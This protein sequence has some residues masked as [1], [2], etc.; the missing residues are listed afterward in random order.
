LETSYN[1]RVYRT[2]VYRGAKVTSY[3]VRWKVG[4]EPHSET[5]RNSTQADS[6]RSEIVA[7]AR[8]GEAF[9]VETG[10]PVSLERKQETPSPRQLAWYQ[11]ACSYA[12]MKWRYSSPNYRRSIAEALTDATEALL[13]DAPMR[14]PSA[15][16]RKALR[17]WAFS[18]RIRNQESAPPPELASVI[19]WLESNTVAMAELNGADGA[20]LVRGVLDRLSTLLNG[21][22][23]APNTAT[24]KR[25]VFVNAMSYACETGAL[26]ADPL[27]AV[28]WT[29]PRLVHVVDP[30]TV[31]NADQARSF[32]AAVRKQGEW[33]TRLEAFFASM[34][35]AALRPEEV[36]ELGMPNLRSLPETGWGELLLTGAAPR[37]GTLW[38]ENGKSRER[39]PLKHRAIADSRTVPAHPE[40]VTVLL[41][42]I[43][44]FGPVT[45]RLFTGPLGGTINERTYLAVFHAARSAVLSEDEL[46]SPLLDVPYALRHA[47]VSTWL[48]AG[49]PATQ[50][51]EW[52]GHSVAVLLRVY[53]KCIAGK[54]DEAKRLIDAATRP[55]RS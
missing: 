30:R 2:E 29:K 41:R 6:F 50:V 23:A 3:R 27:A 43:E 40:L 5:F 7:A 35:Y 37:S 38:T 31:V 1:V 32:L 49:V 52:A 4:K 46:A 47:A 42:H 18:S 24:R 28:K 21:S 19:Q 34:Y 16:L 33:G 14:P 39:Q 13:T 25:M 22:K 12:A 17:E 51:A 9:Y 45:G 36:I 44:L 20:A 8:K 53:A 54:Q 48:N 10:R 26:P 15:D 55:A 11:F